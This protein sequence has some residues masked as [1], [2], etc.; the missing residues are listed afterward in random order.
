MGVVYIAHPVFGF[1]ESLVALVNNLRED[2]D[3]HGE[4]KICS[5]PYK[6]NSL[7]NVRDFCSIVGRELG[8]IIIFKPVQKNVIEEIRHRLE[9]RVP[10]FIEESSD[11]AEKLRETVEFSISRFK[12]GDP[13]WSLDVIVALLLI[14]KLDKER[15][16]AGNNKKGY[17]WSDDLHKGRG[18]DEKYKSRLPCIIGLRLQN[19]ILIQKPSRSRNKYALNPDKREYIYKILQNKEFPSNVEKLLQKCSDHESARVLD[20]LD[21][22]NKE[23]TRT[24]HH[25]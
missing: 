9:K 13:I 20:I 24:S 16:W 22:Y 12:A 19:E 21:S 5:C 8:P 18:V 11:T 1:E 25:Q 17:M 10:I 14:M 2:Y 6:N 4:W 7:L 23:L 3:K 15:K